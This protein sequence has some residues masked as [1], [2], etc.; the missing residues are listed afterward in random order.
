MIAEM[1]HKSPNEGVKTL[2]KAFMEKFEL[3]V[4]TGRT[5]RNCN[6]SF[7]WREK[8]TLKTLE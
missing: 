4:A 7:R 5:K 2:R 8:I 6:F 3:E 1:D